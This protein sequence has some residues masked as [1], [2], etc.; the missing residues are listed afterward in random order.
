MSLTQLFGGSVFGQSAKLIAVQA[1]AEAKAANLL[2]QTHIDECT[3]RWERLQ[4][5]L[6]ELNAERRQGER[7][8][9]ARIDAQNRWALGLLVSVAGTL[10]L[11]VVFLVVRALVSH[12]IL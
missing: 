3:R 11:A 2:T 12:G 10:V 9:V 7:I 5:Q 4:A 6:E 1:L 8:I